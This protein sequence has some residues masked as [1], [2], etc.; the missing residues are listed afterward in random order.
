LNNQVSYF[1]KTAFEIQ[2]QP[3]N[4][5]FRANSIAKDSSQS[6]EFYR[7]NKK[8]GAGF[9]RRLTH[10]SSTMTSASFR[11]VS[12]IRLPMQRTRRHTLRS[13]THFRTKR[14]KN[15]QINSNANAQTSRIATSIASYSITRWRDA[16]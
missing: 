16:A 14:P 3:G 1:P 5:W 4:L 8:V 6:L 13:H 2:I 15:L 12:H 10:G 9:S 7:I 11:W